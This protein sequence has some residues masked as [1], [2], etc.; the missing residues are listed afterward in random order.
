MNNNTLSHCTEIT[1]RQRVESVLQGGHA[2]RVPFTGYYRRFPQCTTERLLRNRGMCMIK[3]LKP[4]VLRWPNVN[5]REEAWW[6]DGRRFVRTYYE[7]PKGT[8]TTLHEE[9]GFTNWYHEYMFKSPEDYPALLYY[10]ENSECEPDYEQFSADQVSSGEDVSFRAD[11][12]AEP[13][14]KLISGHMFGT[15]QFCFEWQDNRDKILELYETIVAK[16]REQ[17]PI[18]AKGPALYSNYGGNISSQVVSPDMF[19]Q[20]YVPHYNEMAR[21]MHKHGKLLG[22]HFDGDCASLSN[23]IAE[24]DLDYIEAFTP[25]PDTDMTLA[26]ARTAWPDKVL[27]L[28]FPSSVHLKSKEHIASTAEKLVDEAGSPDGLI[29]GIT[30]KVPDDRWQVSY[31]A[32]MDGLERHAIAHPDRYGS[33]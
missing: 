29:M 12:G 23:A 11:I 8:L 14:Q 26:E 5:H 25:S 9:A 1:P 19:R 16:R 3:R 21:V 2:D 6:E 31:K 22:C 4:F 30:E 28:N 27:W 17:Y 33:S 32:I 10:I 13:M 15:Q 20:Y 18:V 7:T 24:T